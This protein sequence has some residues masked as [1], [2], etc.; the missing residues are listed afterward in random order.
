VIEVIKGGLFTTVQDGGR[1]GMQR[2]GIPPAGAMD[3]FALALANLL[4]GNPPDGAALEITV[5][6]PVLRAE[7]D[8]VVALGGADLGATMDGVPLPLWKSVRWE[9]GAVISFRGKPLGARVYLAVAGGIDVPPVLGSRSTYV[10][11]RIGG[12]NGRALRAG[13]RLPVGIPRLPLSR[14]TGRFLPRELVPDYPVHKRLRAVPGPHADRFSERGLKTF[15]SGEYVVDTRS[16]R[17]GLCLTGPAVELR[18]RNEMI[19]G[20]VTF[21]AVQVPPDGQPILLMADRQTTGG[22]PLVATVITADLPL[23][24]QALTG[25]S[26][27]FVPVSVEEAHA[28]YR[29]RWRLIWRLRVHG[30]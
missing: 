23:A 6:G 21:G 11:A 30:L 15:F 29:E 3:P 13:D 1:R 26:L 8:L 25:D 12:V 2:Y 17:I 22:Y 7:R 10:P 19:S 18:N 28:L 9:R 20:P 4:V 16:D 14:L 5:V 24:A 27:S